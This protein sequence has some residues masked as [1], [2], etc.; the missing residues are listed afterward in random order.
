MKEDGAECPI[1][2]LGIADLFGFTVHVSWISL[3]IFFLINKQVFSP[4]QAQ[5]MALVGADK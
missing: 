2:A 3:V 4:T 5:G 1:D